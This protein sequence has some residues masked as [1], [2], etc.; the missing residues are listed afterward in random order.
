[1]QKSC[2]NEQANKTRNEIMSLSSAV[3]RDLRL[4][5]SCQS[6]SYWNSSKVCNEIKIHELYNISVLI[7]IIIQVHLSQQTKAL[8]PEMNNFQKSSKSLS[9]FFF[10]LM[11]LLT[12]H[13]LAYLAALFSLLSFRMCEKILVHLPDNTRFLRHWNEIWCSRN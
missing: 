13:S 3:A 5:T 4:E 12:S 11:L 10:L 9:R 2:Q 1:M 7:S 6:K 8:S